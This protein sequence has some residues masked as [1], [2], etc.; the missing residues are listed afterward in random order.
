MYSK[1]N[2]DDFFVLTGFIGYLDFTH[3]KVW[4]VFN[5]KKFD[6]NSQISFIFNFE[7]IRK[8]SMNQWHI[9]DCSSK[10]RSRHSTVLLHCLLQNLPEQ[11]LR[12]MLHFLSNRAHHLDQQK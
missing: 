11:S 7:Y 1:L 9:K 8:R 12:S 2:M 3:C 6:F 10:F 5:K 4:M